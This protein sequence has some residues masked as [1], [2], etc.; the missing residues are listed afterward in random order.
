MTTNSEKNEKQDG[1]NQLE[2]STEEETAKGVYSN[3]AR[4]TYTENEF[5]LGFVL[6]I[7]NEAHLV[8]RVIV[9]P[10]HMEE[11]SKAMQESLAEY[12]EEFE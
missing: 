9:S 8:S 3:L 12:K 6:N 7:D 5:I 11:L 10:D 4:I 2:V 1:M